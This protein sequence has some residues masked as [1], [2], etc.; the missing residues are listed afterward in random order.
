MKPL[1]E[2]K[3]TTQK[4]YRINGGSTQLKGVTPD[5]VLPDNFHYLKVGE[6]DY[7]NAMEWTE[8]DPVEFDLPEYQLDQPMVQ[9]S[10]DH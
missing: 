7:D 9:I 6:K 3:M 2:V 4:F 5:I 10:V 1:G 8:I